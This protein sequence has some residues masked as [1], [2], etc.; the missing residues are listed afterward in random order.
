MS[1]ILGT[2]WI[3]LHVPGSRSLKDKRRVIKSIKERIKGEYNVSI[4]EIGGLDSW[5]RSEIGIACVGND[6]QRID[7]ILSKIL[8]KFRNDP[9]LS[10]IDYTIQ[11]L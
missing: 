1:M 7:R 5:Q 8:D 3:D 11:V 4:A 10:L 9:S 6:K 2:C